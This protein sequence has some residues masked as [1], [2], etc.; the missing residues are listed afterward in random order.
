[1]PTATPSTLT[2][3]PSS[4]R[5][6]VAAGAGVCI[7][8]GEICR[9]K[10]VPAKPTRVANQK[11]LRV[12][13]TRNQRKGFTRAKARETCRVDC[14]GRR[15]CH[16]QFTLPRASWGRGREAYNGISDPDKGA[17]TPDRRIPVS[18]TTSGG[19]G[20]GSTTVFAVE[21]W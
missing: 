14:Q 17:D 6:A 8:S 7:I 9:R 18:F 16:S 2:K 3:P 12:R 5:A 10:A 1:V 19:G 4:S 13:S 20:G 15:R 21:P 11:P